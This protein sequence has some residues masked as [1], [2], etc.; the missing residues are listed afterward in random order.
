MS[1]C[2]YDNGYHGDEVIIVIIMDGERNQ[3][4]GSPVHWTPHAVITLTIHYDQQLHTAIIQY[5]PQHILM[6][7]EVAGVILKQSNP[8]PLY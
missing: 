4:M 3:S 7:K 1:V 6:F 2:C 8:T 5:I